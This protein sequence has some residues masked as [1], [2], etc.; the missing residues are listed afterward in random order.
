MI[1]DFRITISVNQLTTK[2]SG[3]S[4]LF[5]LF[6][7]LDILN[8]KSEIS[9]RKLRTFVTIFTLDRFLSLLLKFKSK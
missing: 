4:E 1:Y 5:F 2:S 3:F 6:S 9:N 8:Q 7:F